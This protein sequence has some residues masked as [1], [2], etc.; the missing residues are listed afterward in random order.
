MTTLLVVLRRRMGVIAPGLTDA[1]VR[2]FW[3]AAAMTVALM[4][5]SWLLHTLHRTTGKSIAQLAFFLVTLGIGAAVYLGVCNW[6]G[7]EEVQRVRGM[8]MHRL[9]RRGEKTN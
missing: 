4:P 8:V 7:V 9:G 1:L 2:I 6:L 3:A 5:C